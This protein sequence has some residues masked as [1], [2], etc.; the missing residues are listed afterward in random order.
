MLG[1]ILKKL[2][3][4]IGPLSFLLETWASIHWGRGDMSLQLSGQGTPV[5]LSPQ[6]EVIVTWPYSP[7]LH[8]Y[9][10]KVDFKIR[11]IIR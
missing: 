8:F 6:N 7:L 2:S 11:P 5:T 4:Q 9:H 10:Q 1:K 3:F